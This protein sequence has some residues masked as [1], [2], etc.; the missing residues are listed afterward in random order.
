MMFSTILISESTFTHSYKH[1]VPLYID[2][3]NIQAL[4]KRKTTN[5]EDRLSLKVDKFNIS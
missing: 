2:L 1:L 4:Q 3:G 5:E